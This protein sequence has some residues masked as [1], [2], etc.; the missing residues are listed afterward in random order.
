V[1]SRDKLA[2]LVA[3]GTLATSSS[4]FVFI[5]DGAWPSGTQI[6]LHLHLSEQPVPSTVN[7]DGSTSWD[8][9]FSESADRWNTHLALASVHLTVLGG[10]PEPV[11]EEN[12]RNDVFW[13]TTLLG[14]PL[15]PEV[16]AITTSRTR[17]GKRIEA[18]VV[19][20]QNILW[21]S[22]R[23]PGAPQVGRIPVAW[24]F[25]R[26]AAHELGHVLGLDHPDEADQAQQALMNSAIGKLDDVTIDDIDGAHAL[27]G[28]EG[29]PL[30]EQRPGLSF[31]DCRE[32]CRRP[33]PAVC[34]RMCQ[35]RSK[36][37]LPRCGRASVRVCQRAGRCPGD[38]YVTS[39]TN[40]P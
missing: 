12:E 15:P 30:P 6:V 37:C 27:Y 22:Y 10:S 40:P 38:P 1:R 24:D 14:R 3:L 7:L 36:R 26:V 17:S 11:R 34:K 21:D 18:D 39:S 33:A 9:V 23:G 19:F 13:S 2:A 5:R 16:L 32:Q 20:N 4:A 8:N 35:D 31:E 25:R 28:G 29:P